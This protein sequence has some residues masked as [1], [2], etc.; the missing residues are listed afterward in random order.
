MP[1]APLVALSA[2]RSFIL[3]AACVAGLVM[4][5]G[6]LPAVVRLEVSAWLAASI[7][8][9]LM[10]RWTAA[11]ATRTFIHASESLGRTVGWGAALGL[12]NVPV[13]FL[14][15]A[16][17]T[18]DQ[19]Q[20]MLLVPLATVMGA[21]YGIAL[22]LAFG[23][24]LSI[25][26]GAMMAT[27]QHPSAAASDRTVFIVGLWIAALAI[28]SAFVAPHTHSNFSL[29]GNPNPYPP[30]RLLGF[31]GIGIAVGGLALA[32]LAAHRWLTRRR[33][34][35]EVA[36]GRRPGWI[37]VQGPAPTE[38]FDTLPT[39]GGTRAAC[40]HILHRCDMV[41]GHTTYRATTTSWPVAWVPTVW[42]SAWLSRS[43]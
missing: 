8:T 21:P 38:R 17:I 3:N 42:L 10:V 16:A 15:A 28:A 20:S 30:I 25:P 11:L 2:L 41:G 26:V 6:S 7:A 4:G 35:I 24:V 23:F 34:V 36:H 37:L 12:L 5:M 1:P 29:W 32:T 43:G 27:S 39:L 40:S 33:F 14:A 13:S 22:G 18:P 19:P 9:A 31:L